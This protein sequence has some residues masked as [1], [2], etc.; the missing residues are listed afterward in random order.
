[1][2]LHSYHRSHHLKENRGR[3]EPG[4]VDEEGVDALELGLVDNRRG[5]RGLGACT[6]EPCMVDPSLLEGS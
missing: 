2:D 6:M 3:Q 1:M 5:S 4:V